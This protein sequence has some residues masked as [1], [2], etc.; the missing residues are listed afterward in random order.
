M[1]NLLLMRVH[2]ESSSVMHA[3]SGR[4]FRSQVLYGWRPD[5]TAR[6]RLWESN[7]V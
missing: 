4:H 6:W 5:S 3:T 2:A 7:V 1:F